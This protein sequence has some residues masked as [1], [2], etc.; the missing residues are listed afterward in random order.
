MFPRQIAFE[1]TLFLIRGCAIRDNLLNFPLP[2]GNIK[3]IMYTPK[4]K[5]VLVHSSSFFSAKRVHQFYST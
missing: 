3:L 1:L 5:N 4:L 2:L